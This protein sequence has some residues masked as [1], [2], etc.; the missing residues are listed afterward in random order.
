MGAWTFPAVLTIII[1]AMN[2]V[3]ASSV[4]G[5]CYIG[6]QNTS[7]RI[8]FL[9]LPYSLFAIA[10]AYYSGR[11]ILFLSGVYF[12]PDFLS[13]KESYKVKATLLRIGFFSVMTA[14]LILVSFLCQIY[15]FL[16][17][18]LWKKS[19]EE[20]VICNLK[21]QIASEGR[22]LEECG[23]QDRPNQTLLELQLL[24]MF[25]AGLLASS[26]VYTK[27]SM[28]SWRLFLQQLI[29]R[30]KSQRPLR[31]KKHEMIAQA[32]SKRRE[33]QENGRLSL[34]LQSAHVDPLG[35]NVELGDDSSG[36][37][38]STWAAA[39]PY[40]VQRRGG[41]C[42]AEQL[43]LGRRNS[44]DSLN[45]SVSQSVSIRSRFSLFDS[46]K[47]SVDSQSLFNTDLE[48]LQSIY[49]N[50]VKKTGRKSKRDFFKSHAQK[51]RPWSRLSRRSS[52]S[53]RDSSYSRN[54]RDS[55]YSR[56]RRDSSYSRN[57]RDSSY[58]RNSRNSDN[59]INSQILPAITLD[60]AKLK[61]PKHRRSEYSVPEPGKST[62][63]GRP[64]TGI[65]PTDPTYRELEEKLR[66]LANISRTSNNTL[67]DGSLTLK[68]AEVQASF[69]RSVQTSLT[70]LSSLG[71]RVHPS[72]TGQRVHTAST[73]TQMTPEPV[74]RGVMQVDDLAAGTQAPASSVATTADNSATTT[75]NNSSTPSSTTPLQH[76]EANVV[77][78]KVCGPS[79]EDSSIPSSLD[80]DIKLRRLVGKGRTGAGKENTNTTTPSAEEA[81]TELTVARIEIP[82][83]KQHKGGPLIKPRDHNRG[84]R[85]AIVEKISPKAEAQDNR[86]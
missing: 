83:L 56:N 80:Q 68:S 12:T 30:R 73:G 14:V 31:L 71:Q 74:V 66:H 10:G 4:Y 16:N 81:E 54:R 58:S 49:D 34:T 67:R 11:C 18:D 45:S 32:F 1:M 51:V 47:Q 85:G 28:H 70:D 37:I 61:L 57:R 3:E 76:I 50:S 78:I 35:M 62:D 40:L 39:L 25:G 86:N 77:S 15:E 79:S 84:R 38:S 41:V 44:L 52:A 7:T 46:R 26:W 72:S 21:S 82:A 9:L 13:E 2:Q 60:P 63:F 23:I 29:T 8:I 36:D 65:L 43:G 6:F 48:R 53:R 27:E 33:L 24:C 22:G 64:R 69:S 59:S 17:I 20:L 75:T 5:I 42:G 19:I 55:S